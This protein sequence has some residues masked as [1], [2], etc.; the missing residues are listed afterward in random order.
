[1]D[2]IKLV[3]YANQKVYEIL[4]DELQRISRDLSMSIHIGEIETQSVV[5]AALTVLLIRNRIILIQKDATPPK[6]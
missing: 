4:G 5:L 6:V 1:M 2:C 3:D